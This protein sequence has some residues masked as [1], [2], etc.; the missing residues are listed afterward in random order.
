MSLMLYNVTDNTKYLF[1]IVPTFNWT[2][3]YQLMKIAMPTGDDDEAIINS[4]MG[5]DA[6]FDIN[7]EI[8][9]RATVTG[10][11]DYT[12]ET[13]TPVANDIDAESNWLKYTVCKESN[14]LYRLIRTRD[15]LSKDGSIANISIF[16]K[17][18][19]PNRMFGKLK[20]SEGVLPAAEE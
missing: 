1:N 20:F 8:T 9:P 18:E 17:G 7:F 19:E 13:G 3:D 5:A 4:L 15:S 12:A 16:E 10:A 2:K 11:N 14:K 6:T